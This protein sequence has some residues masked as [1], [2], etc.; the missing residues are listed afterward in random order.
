M[1]KYIFGLLL[2][3]CYQTLYAQ[4]SLQN[5][6]YPLVEEGKTWWYESAYNCDSDNYF[7]YGVR[8]EGNM[9][10]DGEV[11]Q[12]CWY[13]DPS[14]R[15][16]ISIP[17]ILIREEDKKV[18]VKPYLQDTYVDLSQFDEKD[19]LY[20]QV[21]CGFAD[22]SH[23]I[24]SM[25]DRDEFIIYDFNLRFSQ[26]GTLFQTSGNY[27]SGKPAVIG[28]S[29]ILNTNRIL[30]SLE[31]SSSGSYSDDD[32]YVHEIDHTNR[33]TDRI[34]K[35]AM[36]ESVG[37]LDDHYKGLFYDP[38]PYIYTLSG[39]SFW[40]E[41]MTNYPTP[42]TLL[43]VTDKYN[44]ILFEGYGGVKPW[45]FA[46]TEKSELTDNISITYNNDRLCFQ[47][48]EYAKCR[49]Y[50][51][52]GTLQEIYEIRDNSELEILQFPAG[53]YIAEIDM[54]GKSIKSLKFN[55]E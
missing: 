43:Y 11:W 15:K 45:E 50:S 40:Y 20:K 46:S 51:V 17:L 49:I 6:Y 53:I 4:L 28:E 12:K 29:Y 32:E 52:D 30:R 26:K 35:N 36:I 21:I 25:R 16:I 18:Y 19:I 41:V 14:G 42:P 39:G 47:G 55:I 9:M 44:N 48:I 33:F 5:I 1:K 31:I 34:F 23:S 10:I 8:I 24:D 22:E 37:Y 54:F 2:L 27:N 38:A 13:I 7:Y 3:M